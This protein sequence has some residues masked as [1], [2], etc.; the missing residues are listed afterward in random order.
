MEMIVQN[1]RM[2]LT[3]KWKPQMQRLL[4]SRSWN[5]SDR[6]RSRWLERMDNCQQSMVIF[7]SENKHVELKIMSSVDS[8]DYCAATIIKIADFDLLFRYVQSFWEPI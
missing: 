7:C 8:I 3:F 6:T 2:R 1:F 5:V 4:V